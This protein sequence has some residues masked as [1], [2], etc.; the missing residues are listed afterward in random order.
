MET[1][2]D[3]M[4]TSAP[5]SAVPVNKNSVVPKTWDDLMS[6]GVPT[7]PVSTTPVVEQ[8]IV[9][10]E[11]GN[12]SEND[13][14]QDQYYQPIKEYMKIRFN[15]DDFRGYSRKDLVNKFLNNMRGFSGGNSIRAFNEISFLNELDPEKQKDKLSKVG[16]AYTLYENMQGLFGDTTLGE[17]AGVVGDFA[18][19][20]LLD[21]LTYLG[22]GIG[23]AVVA[24]SGK[25]A[26][27]VAQKTAMNTYKKS[28]AKGA[29]EKVAKEAADKVWAGSMIKASK[30]TASLAVKNRIKKNSNLG[31]KA[32][33]KKEAWMEI[34]G[35]TVT[36]MIAGAGTAIAYENGLV[37]TT[38]KDANYVFAGGMGAI[39][40]MVVGGAQGALAVR[41]AS[42]GGKARKTALGGSGQNKTLGTED[43]AIPT[44]D[45]KAPKPFTDLQ[46]HTT[47]LRK[48][49]SQVDEGSWKL[50]T[51]EG[52][53][54]SDYGDTFIK[55]MLLG[56]D[57]KGLVGLLD[58]MYKQGYV[59]IERSPEDKI[60]NFI[61][62][63][64]KVA[65]P[66]DVKN[67]FKD[68]EDMTG[69]TVYTS[70]ETGK[71]INLKDFTPED[72]SNAVASWAKKQGQGLNALSQASNKLSPTRNPEDYTPNKFIKSLWDTGLAKPKPEERKSLFR[73]SVTGI[74]DALGTSSEGIKSGQNRVIRLLVSS[75]STSMLNLIGWG[76][77]T[78]INSLTD[79]GLG[80]VFAGKA[81][82]QKLIRN[83]DASESW[84]VATSY[85]KANKQ[86]VRNMLDP[87]MTHEAFKAIVAKEPQA[88]ASL[89]RVLPGGIEDID[90]IVKA[91]GFDPKQTLAGSLSEDTVEIIQKI[92]L[93][94]MQD[95]FTKS[96]E[97]VYQLDKNLRLAYD[98]SW[99]E[100]YNTPNA[101]VLMNQRQYKEAVAKASEETQKAIFSK[102]YKDETSIG[103]VAGLIEN[104]R[105]ITGIGLLVPFG[106]FFNNTVA[107][108]MDMTGLSF[109]A[110]ATSDVGSKLGLSKGSTQSRTAKELAMRG[111]IGLGLIHSLAQ[112]E[113]IYRE[114]GLAWDQRFDT[115]EIPFTSTEIF[116][117][118]GAV[119]T[120]RY[121]FPYS[122][123]KGAA[124]IWSYWM[125]GDSENIPQEEV[126]NIV[127]T[128][129]LD[130]LTRQLDE[131]AEGLGQT[132]RKGIAGE[133]NVLDGIARMTGQV[134]SQATSGATRFLDPYNSVI[135][136]TRGP[137]FKVINRK[138]G[139]QL[140]NNS[141]RYMDQFIGAISGDLASEKQDATVG[142]VRSTASKQLGVREV[143]LTDSAK[144]F[145]MIGKPNYLANRKT[146]LAVAG[147][148]YNEI[149]HE[150]IELSA[151]D[152]IKSKVFREGDVLNLSASINRKKLTKLDIRQSLV[153]QAVEKAKAL[154]KWTMET[155][156][157]DVND[158]QL[159]E[160]MNLERKYGLP[161]LDEAIKGF[162]E[163]M[164]EGIELKDL[165]HS[166]LELLESYM[167]YQGYV[168]KL[169]QNPN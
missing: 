80:A 105:N 30:D 152:I 91:S 21:P 71:V 163:G 116:T 2:D 167:E 16:E 84:R 5:K 73:G 119:V 128:L 110:K 126:D 143:E 50:K 111:A 139:S 36:D 92:S 72:F 74:S 60:S 24:G 109:A 62:D 52:K 14:I 19:E 25:I 34:G 18:R 44:V 82:F 120:E 147:N 140:L 136:L 15:V 78:S 17:K 23:K 133:I 9:N 158:L 55:E 40:A 89:A 20:T 33:G 132:F 168:E 77:A 112:N 156:F 6:T 76:S 28:L 95:V 37:R 127:D 68:F 63:V 164:D 53:D 165:N 123:F 87:N 161:Q 57:E 141:L 100:F 61:T 124:R 107:F 81:G 48:Y 75:P 169:Y 101:S 42:G 96:Q 46:T 58:V 155:G 135:G 29:T 104:A 129:G 39:G 8:P 51:N 54:L 12:Y 160:I 35:V 130:Q 93:V 154:T 106:R 138:E 102:S 88:L 150:I 49:L 137:D 145:N 43:L 26:T 122:H 10:L 144:M 64:I 22:F 41:A 125:E 4:S 94:K 45:V 134:A 79:V 65:D 13:L 59:F 118:T 149:F 148:R 70:P 27:R 114:Q 146:K 108:S 159:M 66:Q 151:S 117:G 38:D 162:K 121:N 99:S 142:D 83:N 32:F 113:K 85:F 153:K 56:N 31:F 1:W 69:I 47:S 11:G 103:E 67:F 115:N 97:F 86:R 131:A 90:K 166:Q 157:E 98:K 7:T 3:L